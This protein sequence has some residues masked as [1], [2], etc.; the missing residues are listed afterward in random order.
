[1]IHVIAQIQL[2]PDSRKKFLAEFNQV[3]PLVRAEAG[4]IEYAAAVDAT[5]D[6]ERQHRDPDRI[7]I[8]EKWE[9]LRHLQN[10]LTA[11]HMLDYRER[12][13]VMIQNAQLNILDPA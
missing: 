4:C 3:V 8:I 2:V 11:P 9:T 13:G 5:S 10:H 1:M 7:I 6:L 12:V